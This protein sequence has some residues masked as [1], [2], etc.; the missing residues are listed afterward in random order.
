MKNFEPGFFVK[1]A[2]VA[3]VVLLLLNL[4]VMPTNAKEEQETSKYH[5]LVLFSNQTGLTSTEENESAIRI[6]LSERFQE[7]Q[8]YT[9]YMDSQRIFGDGYHDLLAEY[10][11]YKYDQVPLDGIIVV[12][13]EAYHFIDNRGDLFSQLP[14]V[15][16]DLD[17]CDELLHKGSRVEGYYHNIPFEDMIRTAKQLNPDLRKISIY[18][19][20]SFDINHYTSVIRDLMEDNHL[21]YE[22]HNQNNVQTATEQMATMNG[23]EIA[24]LL[25]GLPNTE[26]R[27]LSLDEVFSIISLQGPAPVMT[28]QSTYVGKGAV[29]AVFYE[30]KA[31]MDATISLLASRIGR[32]EGDLEGTL[33]YKVK[34]P[35]IEVDY[36]AATTLGL[37][38]K[39]FG[40]EVRVINEPSLMF[41]LQDNIYEFMII[42]LIVVLLVLLFA[43]TNVLLRYRAEKDRESYRHDLSLSYMELEAAHAQLVA[44]E[45]ELSRQ[46]SELKIKEDELR[47]S[48]ERYRL[49]ANGSEF[50]IWDYDLISDELYFSQKARQVLGIIQNR[51][52]FSMEDFYERIGPKGAQILKKKID[53]H[54]KRL[55]K[56]IGL[57]SQILGESGE[58]IHLSIR[59]KAQFDDQGNVVRLAGSIMDITKE[60]TAQEKIEKIAYT[61]DLT[62]LKN[63]AYYNERIAKHPRD[64]GFGIVL[65]DLDNFKTIN[66]SMGHGFGDDVLIYVAKIIVELVPE[67]VEVIRLGGDEF[68]LLFEAMASRAY[69]EEVCDTIYDFF[70]KHVVIEG[71]GLNLTISMGA[72]IFPLDCDQLDTLLKQADMALYEAKDRGKNRLAFYTPALE[73]QMIQNL[74]YERELKNA[75]ET[76]QFELYYQPKYHV[77][78]ESIVGYEALIRWI[79]PERGIISPAEFIPIAE[80]LGMIIPIGKWVIEEAVRQLEAWYDLGHK[81]LTISINISAIQF[82]DPNLLK[83]FDECFR[84]RRVGTHQIELEITETAAL[85]DV[86]YAIGILK[87]FKDRGYLIAL[88]D[89]GTG[90]SSLNYL[91]MLPIDTLKIDKSFVAKASQDKAV[92]IMIETIIR[93]AHA[94]EME[95]VAEG[96]ETKEQQDFLMSHACD[97]LQGYLIARP[98]PPQEAI[99]YVNSIL[100]SDF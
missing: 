75:V 4:F 64:I 53:R 88:D 40:D 91:H 56:V 84:N 97:M 68:I 8:L 79:H 19:K 12:G 70:N 46:F 28:I 87:D 59:G 69:M 41:F 7:F 26:G 85:H 31:Y 17:C 5:I 63:R 37:T 100:I 44:S 90:Y 10:L 11:P 45:E 62:G 34:A 42:A 93:L 65:M 50:G 55:D 23:T 14:V 36:V 80:E 73:E 38:V 98:Y 21:L 43:F 89:F 77:N 33:T 51:L 78:A 2:L 24:F 86:E 52:V 3:F 1:Q 30:K 94:Y 6:A 9:E 20:P 81:D 96:V 83:S 72:A 18:T 27:L 58:T 49:A 29:G 25:T 39:N 15:H 74:W 61:D 99:T 92:R 71:Y 32:Y 82:M 95:V 54:V 60:K 66:D 67:E 13:D 22:I 16:L 35:I 57:E 47:K 76:N 48:R